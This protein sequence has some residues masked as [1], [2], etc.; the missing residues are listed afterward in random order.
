M[1]SLFILQT[2]D[3]KQEILSMAELEKFKKFLD[4]LKSEDSSTSLALSG[5]SSPFALHVS[6]SVYPWILDSGA[7]DHMTPTASQFVTYQPSP[8][9]KKISLADGSLTTAAGYGD[10]QIKPEILLKN[11]L[12]VP[13]LSTSLVSI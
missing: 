10:I 12:H 8:S 4:S 1:G 6:A 11:V 7:T 2:A 5:I 3:S 13:K 9:N